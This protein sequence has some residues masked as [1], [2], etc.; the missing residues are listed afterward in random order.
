M[1]DVARLLESFADTIV[2]LA[3]PTLRTLVQ[4][5][6]VELGRL[7]TEHNAVVLEDV[8]IGREAF[9]G[10]LRSGKDFQ[11]RIRLSV[12]PGPALDAWV[13]GELTIGLTRGRVGTF[14]DAL[15][16]LTGRDVTLPSW[17]PRDAQ[18]DGELSWTAAA[19]EALE[20][21]LAGTF[22][23]A[24]IGF[25]L[26]RPRFVPPVMV[27]GLV[28]EVRYDGRLSLHAMALAHGHPLD[29][30]LEGS[31]VSVKAPLV[32]V[33]FVR[34]VLRTLGTDVKLPDEAIFALDLRIEN[35]VVLGEIG[36]SHIAVDVA[37]SSFV[38]IDVRARVRIDRARVMWNALEGRAHG[39]T[40]STRGVFLRDDRSFLATGSVSDIVVDSIPMLAGRVTATAVRGRLDGTVRARRRAGEHVIGDGSIVLR[41]G[42]FPVLDRIGPMLDRYGLVPP[43]QE[44]TAPATATLRATAS[45]FLVEDI[46]VALP[47]ATARGSVGVSHERAL[48]GA[49]EVTVAD[50]YLKKSK[51]LTLPRVF[52]DRL[53]VPIK[54][55]GTLDAPS[56][57]AEVGSTLGRALVDNRMTAWLGRDRAPKSKD[58]VEISDDAAIEAELDAVLAEAGWN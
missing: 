19:G 45:G 4:R 20:G 48:E 23:A 11:A 46:V 3:L 30:V 24:E 58:A 56:I 44:A 49:I 6:R 39:G 36:V 32:D 31:A 9:E 50:E 1:T 38:I 21:R 22:R 8:S 10:T 12:A 13:W 27:H 16:A 47:G 17:V 7:A 41:D 28:G 42:A 55:G 18:V 25:R 43:Q 2:G 33:V 57:S 51:L 53:A 15:G 52:V 26:G 37:G 34:D 14:C 5:E 54:I 40:F 29:I 35:E